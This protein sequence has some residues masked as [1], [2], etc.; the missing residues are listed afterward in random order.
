[1]P[2]WKKMQIDTL[3]F[4]MY[5]SIDVQLCNYKCLY[6]LKP[7]ECSLWPVFSND[8]DPFGAFNQVR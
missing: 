7:G 2:G 5:C 8:F 6:I 4:L 1:M 3:Y